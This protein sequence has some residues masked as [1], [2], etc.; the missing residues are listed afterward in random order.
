VPSLDPHACPPGNANCQ[1]R[2]N[3]N[4]GPAKL[5]VGGLPK[6]IAN[7]SDGQ[8]RKDPVVLTLPAPKPSTAVSPPASADKSAKPASPAPAP[9]TAVKYGPPVSLLSASPN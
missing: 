3:Q 2:P 7:S 6:R 4:A 9:A 1:A 8:L 5:L